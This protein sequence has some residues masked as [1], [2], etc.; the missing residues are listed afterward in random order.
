M[1]M[2]KLKLNV[3]LKYNITTI[4]KTKSHLRTTVGDDFF[5]LKHKV[6]SGS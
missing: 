4:H 6:G 1:K 5:M 2:M 3:L